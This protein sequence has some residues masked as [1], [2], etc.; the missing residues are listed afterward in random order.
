MTIINTIKRTDIMVPPCSNPT[1]ATVRD[2]TSL[3]V[4]D[5]IQLQ[6]KVD[7]PMIVKYQQV[8]KYR[9]AL[10]RQRNYLALK[11]LEEIKGD[12]DDE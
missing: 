8:P 12:D 7:E 1:E 9:A 10:G 11:I 2:I 3:N 6:H 4:G 5:V